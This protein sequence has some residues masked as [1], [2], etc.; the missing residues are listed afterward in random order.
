M[1]HTTS[2]GKS[3]VTKGVSG[4]RKRGGIA[5][6]AAAAIQARKNA[7]PSNRGSSRAGAQKPA[8]ATPRSKAALSD[9]GTLGRGPKKTRSFGK[10]LAISKT[11][12]KKSGGGAKSKFGSKVR[13]IKGG[14]ITRRAGG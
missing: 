13:R 1:P 14:I 6:K 9:A 5:S 12:P 4:P 8:R 3:A 7:K 11:A 10:K 2:K